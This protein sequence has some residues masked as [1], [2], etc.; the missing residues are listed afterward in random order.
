MMI[1]GL[2]PDVLENAEQQHN[3]HSSVQPSP[4]A[5]GYS[6]PTVS[7]EVCGTVLQLDY[8]SL[9]LLIHGK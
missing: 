3:M 4:L 2:I 6:P 1:Y 9:A 8:I 5:F 7:I